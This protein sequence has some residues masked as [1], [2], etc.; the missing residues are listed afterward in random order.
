M[1]PKKPLATDNVSN[2]SPKLV[3]LSSQYRVLLT[4]I[5]NHFGVPFYRLSHIA[6]KFVN[7]TSVKVVHLPSKSSAPGSSSSSILEPPTAPSSPLLS[8]LSS[9]LP[10]Y[11]FDFGV[12]CDPRESHNPVIPLILLILSIMSCQV[13]TL[14]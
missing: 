1:A 13:V 11:P 4:L 3:E 2:P 14:F 9:H 10:A 12:S 8:D 6:F 5:F 7:T